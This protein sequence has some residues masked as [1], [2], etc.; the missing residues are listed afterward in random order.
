[1]SGGNFVQLSPDFWIDVAFEKAFR[2]MGLDS[3]EAI[4]T[5][6]GGRSLSKASLAKHRSRIQIEIP[7]IP[8]TVYLKR[9]NRAPAFAQIKNWISHC[10][11]ASTMF[12]DLDASR[13]LAE[14]GIKTPRAISYGAR[15]GFLFE[16]QS[17]IATEK[18]P[19]ESLE[20][21]LPPCFA[22]GSFKERRRFIRDLAE[23]AR[24]F[25]D[26][27]YCHR[28]FYFAHIFHHEG[29]FYLID[30][31]RVFKPLMFSRRYR[32]KDIAQLSYSAPGKHFSHADRLR[33]Y[34]IYADRKQLEPKDKSFIRAV[35]RK[36]SQMA[37]HDRRHGRI[38]PF[39][40]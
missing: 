17:F 2:K 4:F 13:K 37:E 7:N 5:F 16:K 15:L 22:V 3:I 8:A 39:E 18:I 33:F 25:H 28:D 24:R 20:R 11:I 21:Q 36:M 35:I 10:R 26:T 27:G 12:Y 1:M 14:A 23:F 19:G 31:H 32:I 30:L 6:E 40:S 9:Y 34:L 38:I 29:S